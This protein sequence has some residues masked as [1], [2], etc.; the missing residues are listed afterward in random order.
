MDTG[1]FVIN[2]ET[3]SEMSVSHINVNFNEQEK[4]DL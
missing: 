3:S 2:N 1:W 4:G